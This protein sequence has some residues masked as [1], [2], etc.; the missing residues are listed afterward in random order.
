MIP[1]KSFHLVHHIRPSI[2]KA[3]RIFSS[4]NIF[5][6]ILVNCFKM[7]KRKAN[8]LEVALDVTHLRRSTRRKPS[9]LEST[10]NE[11]PQP[12]ASEKQKTSNKKV[13]SK[14]LP[15]HLKLKV[16][17]ST[18]TVTQPSTDSKLETTKASGST[19]KSY[20]LL[21]AEPESRFENGVDVKF[22]IDDL[23]SRSEPEPWDGIRNYVARNNLRD[24]KKGDIA[25]FYH[26]NCKAPGIVGTMDIVQEYSPDRMY[27]RSQ[28]C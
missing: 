5:Q 14:V 18:K 28:S 8:Q 21:K 24:M 20:W 9:S 1:I 25:F 12:S 6:V 10:G 22:S 7:V 23:A 4:T 16:K 19:E 15:E 11:A 2:F 27:A 13:D 3:Y 26:S 17:T